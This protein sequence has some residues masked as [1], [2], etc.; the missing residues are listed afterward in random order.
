MANQVRVIVWGLPRTCSSVLLKSL[1]SL[2]DSQMIYELYTDAYFWGPERLDQQNFPTVE[3]GDPAIKLSKDGLLRGSASGFD[4]SIST[5]DWVRRQLEADYPGKK[6]I[7]A[8][9]IAPWLDG[10]Y[11]DLPKGYRHVF[12]I[13]H[14]FK[15]FHSFKKINREFL[16]QKRGHPV[17]LEEAVLDQLPPHIMT[18]GMLYKEMTDLWQYIKDSNLD[19]DPIIVDSDELLQSPQ[20]VLSYLCG[21]LRIPYTDSI[22]SWEKGFNCTGSWVVSQEHKHLIQTMDSFVNFRN[23]TSFLKPKGTSKAP[24]W[25]TVDPDIRRC[26]EFSMPY[27]SQMYDKRGKF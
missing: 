22:L 8:K 21:Q 11:K 27:F 25:S 20:N 16:E 7:I 2:P 9:E 18:P 26:V 12:L 17:G 10:R 23:S 24:D 1:T 15:M 5:F 4:T 6:V 14:P 13:R 3:G 19:P